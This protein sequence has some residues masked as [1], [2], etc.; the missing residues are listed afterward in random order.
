MKE[1]DIALKVI[2]DMVIEGKSIQT[3][4]DNL[5]ALRNDIENRIGTVEK[6]RE[7]EKKRSEEI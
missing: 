7:Q 3:I 6:W 2:N 1:Y 4:L 5:K